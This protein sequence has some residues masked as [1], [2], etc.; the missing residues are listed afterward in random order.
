[1]IDL[2]LYNDS[3]TIF[4]A[5]QL[6][7]NIILTNSTEITKKI[8]KIE[9][10]NNPS[11]EKFENK[12]IDF[13]I[14]I[15]CVIIMY[16]SCKIKSI[17]ACLMIL[18]IFLSF[19]GVF[20]NYAKDAIKL[21]YDSKQHY[22]CATSFFVLLFS[23][24]S[25]R[26]YIS[27]F[28]LLPHVVKEILLLLYLIVKIILTIF[29]TLMNFSITI[30]NLKIL[31]GKRLDRFICNLKKTVLIYNPKYY[32]YKFSSINNRNIVIIIDKIIF[33]I[34]C[35]MFM[36]FNMI[37]K[38]FKTLTNKII[39]GFI[40]IYYSLLNYDSN[41][42]IIIKTILKI[43]FI[44]SLIIVYICIVYESNI[45]SNQIKDIYNLIV[46]V[47]LIP[48]IYDNIKSQNT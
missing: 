23:A 24:Q 45:F 40:K 32:N 1:M 12:T 27:S 16:F 14:N 6:F 30:S 34:T 5:L 7:I 4:I 46:T 2:I 43:S 10:E 13:F 37:L 8:K 25:C 39:N 21:N 9:K 36:I 42:N 19:S 18:T 33:I 48:I 44:W 17:F 28:G 31:F 3:I 15:F 47:L 29:F 20:K 38:L 11:K 22:N 35:P 41:R 26:I